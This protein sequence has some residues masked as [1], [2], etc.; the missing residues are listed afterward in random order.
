MQG[1]M[2]KEIVPAKD[3]TGQT[4]AAT[5]GAH[6][7]AADFP[8]RE[9]RKL[10]KDLWQP[11]VRLYWTDFTISNVLGWGAV[12]VATLSPLG[13]AVQII[14]LVVATLALYRAVIFIHELAHF[15]KGTFV[16]YRRF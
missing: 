8:L 15:R 7:E 5:S 16:A 3:D 14:A 10:V 4:P 9:A 2:E 1:V 6:P 13:S 11:N 12:A